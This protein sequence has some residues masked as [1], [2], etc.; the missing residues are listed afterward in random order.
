LADTTEADTTP[1]DASDDASD[2]NGLPENLDEHARKYIERLTGETATRRHAQRK[3]EGERDDALK[4]L[5]AIKRKH[6][7]DDERRT[8]EATEALD[9]AVKQARDDE[10]AV[11]TAE[12]QRQLFGER[13]RSLAAS[14]FQNADDAVRLLDL[15][16]L[17]GDD[18]KA[19]KAL[20]DLLA[21][22]RLPPR[23]RPRGVLISQGGRSQ[24]PTAPREGWIRRGLT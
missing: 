6:E 23:D 19:E 18:R 16:A 4:Q 2:S 5:D 11:V 21:E 14:R 20:D 7:S 8:R 10:R 17:A 9:Q 15:D 24:P 12:F 1:Q 13:V 22:N 3:A